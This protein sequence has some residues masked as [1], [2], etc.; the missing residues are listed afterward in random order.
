MVE[1]IESDI[2]G[3][4]RMRIVIMLMCAVINRYK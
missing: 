3:E 1:M 2:Y 4:M